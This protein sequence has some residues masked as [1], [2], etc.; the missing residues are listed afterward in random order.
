MTENLLVGVLGN[1]GAGKSFT[2]NYLFK[3]E[4]R[5][6]KHLRKLYLNSREYVEVFLISRSAEERHLDVQNIIKEKQ[7]RIILCSLDYSTP[8]KSTLE[9]F[10]K[11]KFFLFI[12]WLNPGYKE[13]N[14]ESIFYTLG[15][16]NVILKEES[17][18]GIRNANDDIRN[19]TS[20]MKDFIYGW[21][22]SRGLIIK[23][24]KKKG[25]K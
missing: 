23:T 7:P 1:K 17:L 4:V 6:G 5:T 13:S 14:M 22:K 11:N 25:Q 19:R 18:V 3:R 2:W 8:L 21:A 24:A 16:V 12:H 10:V 15:I 20:E 9:Y